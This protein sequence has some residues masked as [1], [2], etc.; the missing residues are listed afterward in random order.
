MLRLEH[1]TLK[2]PGGRLHTQGDGRELR[3]P[4]IGRGQVTSVGRGRYAAH[5]MRAL[6]DA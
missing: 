1:F 6:V 4:I 3:A 5:S 2:S